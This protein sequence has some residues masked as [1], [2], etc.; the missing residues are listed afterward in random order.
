M[1]NDGVRAKGGSCNGVVAFSMDLVIGMCIFEK[2]ADAHDHEEHG[3]G[4]GVGLGR[5]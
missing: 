5:I 1:V 3:E 2:A 4:V